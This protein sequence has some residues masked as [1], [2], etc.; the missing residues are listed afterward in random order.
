MSNQTLGSYQFEW[1]PEKWTIPR[2][3]KY[4]GKVLTYESVGFFSFGMSIVGKEIVLEWD[5]MSLEQWNELDT[6]F[7]ADAGC[8]WLPGD[9]NTYNVEMLHLDGA[10]FEVVDLDL[11]YRR[12]V[13]LTLMIMSIV[14]ES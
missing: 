7:Q 3:E 11:A 13:K 8:V 6:L 5:W 9:G 2:K 12:N 10:Y 4:Y 14:G 1:N